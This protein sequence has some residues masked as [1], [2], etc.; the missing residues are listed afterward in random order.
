VW[1]LARLAALR[2]NDWTLPARR[3]RVLAAA[4]RKD[5]AAAAYDQAARLA[6]SPRDL[7]DWLRAAAAD[8]EAARRY[9]QGLWNLD[10]AVRLTPD[11]WTVYAARALLAHQAGR[12]ERT[13]SDL[14]EVSRR[15][16][17]D[18]GTVARLADV[19]G[20][21][22]EWKRAAALFTSLAR[23]PNVPILVRYCQAVA[24]LK[25]GNPAGYRAACAGIRAQVPPVGPQLMG[26]VAYDAALVF[27]LG[28]NATD[29][30]AQPLAWIDHRLARLEAYEKAHP[31]QKDGLRPEWHL[32]WRTRGALLFR[33]GRCAE[34]AKALGEA[35][36]DHA[37]GGDFDNWAFLALAEHRLGHADAAR[38]AA[39]RARAARAGLKPDTV[40]ERAEVE[41]LAAELDAALPLPDR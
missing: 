37:G 34:A 30:W 20:G 33:A 36:P 15:G 5:E 27:T 41:L 16:A 28:P 29:N 8:D 23:I 2:S 9:D 3:G 17:D 14:D 26:G 18:V 35:L 39:A 32:Y 6:R 24:A 31:D 1:H 10:R 11:D 21:L 22:G 7:A 19:A 25:A 40:W 4:G 13:R 38:K 12:Q